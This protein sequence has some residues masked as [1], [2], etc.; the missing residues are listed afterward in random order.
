MPGVE[1]LDA[2]GIPLLIDAFSYTHRFQSPQPFQR[3]VAAVL[4]DIGSQHAYW[5]YA[6]ENHQLVI[7]A[8][9]SGKI[10]VRPSLICINASKEE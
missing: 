3:G 8:D 4:P 1:V 7:L 2:A 5:L 6:G 10:L 9:A